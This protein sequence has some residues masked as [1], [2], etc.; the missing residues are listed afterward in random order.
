VLGT[1]CLDATT[2]ET[3][4]EFSPGCNE[5]QLTDCSSA[6]QDG[7]CDDSG[8]TAGCVEPCAG[9]LDP[10][11]TLDATQ[12]GT[13]TVLQTCT[14]D[15]NGCL[16]WTDTDC[17]ATQGATYTCAS[18][19]GTG[20]LCSDACSGITECTIGATQCS[21]TTLQTCVADSGGCG[22][23][24]DTDCQNQFGVTAV[25]QSDGA[26]GFECADACASVTECTEGD[27]RCASGDTLE[28]CADNGGGCFTWQATSCPASFPSPAIGVCNDSA[29]PAV[30]EDACSGI[31]ECTTAT[32]TQCGDLV[33]LQTCTAD[34]N[35]CLV[36]VDEVCNQ[37]PNPSTGVCGGTPADCVDS[38][39]LISDCVTEGDT[40]CSN[41]ATLQTCTDDGNGCLLWVDTDCSEAGLS[42]D[43]CV[44]GGVTATCEPLVCT[45]TS[46]CVS[47]EGCIDPSDP[48]SGTATCDH[49]GPGTPGCVDNS[50]TQESCVDDEGCCDPSAECTAGGD[51]CPQTQAIGHNDACGFALAGSL[52]VLADGAS[53]TAP[54]V[55]NGIISEMGRCSLTT[56]T[57]CWDDGMCP[58]AETCARNSDWFYVDF[59]AAVRNSV[60]AQEGIEIK[61]QTN[62][63][64]DYRFRA[65]PNCA[66]PAWSGM[67]ATLAAGV[68]GEGARQWLFY[69]ND[70][71][72]LGGTSDNTP[73]PA[74]VLVEVYRIQN[75]NTCSP[76]KLIVTDY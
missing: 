9:V 65:Y 54:T 46:D 10:C 53:L 18:D 13:T 26:T 62:T 12:C 69:D 57:V 64:G 29:V 58:G 45:D 71:G 67:D 47:G 48:P 42:S 28:T 70:P 20:F 66:V 75:P 11:G 5:L 60:D 41:S 35:G 17:V 76:Y 19:G 55:G 39:A 14:D 23:W 24:S 1:S 33:T 3:C 73:W 44:D 38:C 43:A 22:I 51:C 68:G 6:L 49:E 52:G 74:R 61:F 32:D 34:Q 59:T 25:C 30:C 56:G 50:S 36:L 16:E 8:A 15:G 37:A 7:V 4:Q 72:A 31:T 63:N 21:S 27:T 2:L 40:Q